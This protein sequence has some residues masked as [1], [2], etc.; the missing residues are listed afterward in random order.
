[1]SRIDSAAFSIEDLEGR[2]PMWGGRAHNP[3]LETKQDN[4]EADLKGASG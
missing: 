1:M 4:Y 3:H 2:R